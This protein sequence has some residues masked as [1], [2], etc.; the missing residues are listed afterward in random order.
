MS[1]ADKIKLAIAVVLLLGAIGLAIWYFTGSSAP[2]GGTQL[3][4]APRVPS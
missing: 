1:K 3:D 4:P 2:E